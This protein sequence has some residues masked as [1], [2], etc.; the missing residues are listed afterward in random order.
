MILLDLG[1]VSYET[2]W[3]LQ[4]RTLAARLAGETEDT[5]IIAEHDP[6][7]TLGRRRDA[8]ANVLDPGDTPVIQV[9]RGGDVTWHGPG[10]ITV[11]PIVA[12]PP[13]RRDLHRHMADLEEAAIRTCAEF[14]VAAGRNDRNTGAWIGPRKVCSVGIACRRWVTWH[15]L[16]LNVHP[17]MDAF[18]RINPCG[19]EP[20]VM[21]SM[22]QA[23][24][25]DPDL[26]QVQA[27]LTRH[28]ITL[29]P[30]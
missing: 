9:E 1:R 16:A 23:L 18:A 20:T 8:A 13:G 30:A 22:A 7:Y 26:A 17:D 28:L 25:H 27:A 12:L 5:L 24:G 11:Y 19:M 15:G 21:T 6:V 4:K 3:D 29:L 10:Q 2:S 14:G